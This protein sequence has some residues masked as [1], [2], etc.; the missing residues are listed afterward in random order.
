MRAFWRVLVLWFESITQRWFTEAEPDPIQDPPTQVI[1]VPPNPEENDPEEFGPATPYVLAMMRAGFTVFSNNEK[2]Y[3]LNIVGVRD[4]GARLDEFSCKIVVFWKTPGGRWKLIEWKA[5]TYPG[6]RYLI[7][8]LLNPRGAAILERGQWSVYKID[9][10]N[11]KYPAVCQRRG[12]VRVY[13]DGDLDREFDLDPSTIQSGMFGINIHAPVTP[14]SGFWNYVA[15]RVYNASAGCQ[16]FKSV[17]D[18][19]EFRSLVEKSVKL[20]G[21]AITYTL[22][23]DVDLHQIDITLPSPPPSPGQFDDEETWSP[24]LDTAGIRNKNLLNVKGTG[25]RYSEGSDSR[26]HNIFPSYAKGLRAG[27]KLLSIYWTKHKK[28]TIADILSRW[29]P[30]TDT[31]GSLPGA[32]PNS[33]RDYSLFVASRMD[34][35]PTAPL[36]TFNDD[37]SVNDVEQLF[38]LV[39]AMA[40]YENDAGLQIPRPVFDE[41]VSLL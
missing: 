38:H 26:G 7:E 19:L 32:P 24:G 27:I 37:G 39:S 35:R 22:L 4:T 40:A 3:N 31:I 8:K 20:W 1:P 15:Q 16:V 6:S 11:G 33:P 10:H 41:A 9:I 23:D 12:P 25:W 30:A 36:S 34:H 28:K 17:S 14:R 18:F 5:T 2:D 13:R 29:A 21:N